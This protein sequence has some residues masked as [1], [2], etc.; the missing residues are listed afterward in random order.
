VKKLEMFKLRK[1]MEK[2]PIIRTQNI[3]K[4]KRKNYKQCIAVIFI[5]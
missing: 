3:S 1:S 2:Q 4:I 5:I